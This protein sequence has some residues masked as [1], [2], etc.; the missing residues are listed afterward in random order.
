MQVGPDLIYRSLKDDVLVIGSAT[1]WQIEAQHL[2]VLEDDLGYF[3]NY[4]AAPLI[5]E[6]VL[7]EHPEIA[8]VL[9]RLAGQIDDATMRQLNYEVAVKKRSEK[10]VAREFL[11]EKKLVR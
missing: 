6:D 5:R 2:V 7:Q 11:V 8:E 9:N 3:P 10:D 1:D 4:H